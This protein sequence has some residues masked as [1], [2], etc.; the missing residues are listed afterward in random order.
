MRSGGDRRGSGTKSYLERC[1]THLHEFLTS[2]RY[3]ASS[4]VG[5]QCP[6]V[7]C[8]LPANRHLIVWPGRGS[9]RG[10][11]LPSRQRFVIPVPASVD[12]SRGAGATYEVGLT[13]GHLCLS[14][15]THVWQAP[16]PTQR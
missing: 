11:W 5:L 10:V 9:V 16:L 14:T 1:G 7:A 15:L 2:N 6:A 8:S 12:P 4:P 13:A 3:Q